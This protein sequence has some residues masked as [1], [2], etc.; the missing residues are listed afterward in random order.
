MTNTPYLTNDK[1]SIH[2]LDEV[3]NAAMHRKQE[4]YDAQL[5]GL[6]DEMERRCDELSLSLPALL[7]IA[8]K[9]KRKV[10]TRKD[11]GSTEE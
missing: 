2:E 3:I 5:E 7:A 4:L 8:K 1:L 9:R 11:N 6:L 10:R